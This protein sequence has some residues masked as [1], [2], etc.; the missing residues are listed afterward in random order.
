MQ[1]YAQL[2]NV[3]TTITVRSVKVDDGKNKAKRK[4]LRFTQATKHLEL[5]KQ[6]N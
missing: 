6:L 1:A 4:G 2:P 3:I 5:D